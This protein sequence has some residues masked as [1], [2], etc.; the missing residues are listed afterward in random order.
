[1]VVDAI[2]CAIYSY[3]FLTLVQHNSV[4]ASDYVCDHLCDQVVV[5]VVEVNLAHVAVKA[6]L[7]FDFADTLVTSYVDP[8]YIFSSGIAC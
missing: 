8:F 6:L 4:V 7:A 5:F 2:L 1:M 3:D